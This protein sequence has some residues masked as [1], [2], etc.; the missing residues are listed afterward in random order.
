[1]QSRRE[2]ENKKKENTQKAKTSICFACIKFERHDKNT[3]WKP[4]KMKN[5][6]RHKTSEAAFNQQ[7]YREI[8]PIYA[9]V[10]KEIVLPM[11]DKSQR[12]TTTCRIE[13]SSLIIKIFM[14]YSLKHYWGLLWTHLKTKDAIMWWKLE[15]MN[16]IKWSMM[17][18]TY[19]ESKLK[20]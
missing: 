16:N 2:G 20:N 15:D 17:M 13:N 7:I 10:K 11:T 5:K 12:R 14:H 18:P 1:M 3:I 6:P 9:R 8:I 4:I 19:F